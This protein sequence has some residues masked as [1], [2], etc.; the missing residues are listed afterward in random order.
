MGRFKPIAI[1]ALI[2]AAS[3]SRGAEPYQPPDNTVYLGAGLGLS[4]LNPQENGSGWH[5]ID[6]SSTGVSLFVGYPF[7]KNWVAELTYADLGAATVAPRNEALGHSE[8]I[9]YQVPSLTAAYSFW[10]PRPDVQVFLRAGI[11][12]IMNK[13]SGDTDIYEKNTSA[14]I[15]IGLGAQ[16]HFSEHLFARLDTV[17][18]DVDAQMISLSIGCWIND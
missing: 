10:Y 8:D 11:A 1:A 18:Y 17:S 5:T 6:Q 9:S 12:G 13:N 4:Q 7:Y 14:Q 2:L 16:W 15:A 3:N